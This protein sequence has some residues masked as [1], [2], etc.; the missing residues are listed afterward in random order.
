V[1]Q[2]STN[3][4]LAAYSGTTAFPEQ[5]KY[6]STPDQ[7]TFFALYID[8]NYFA[9]RT[10][11]ANI[12]AFTAAFSSPHQVA[13]SGTGYQ[14]ACFSAD[15]TGL[16]LLDLGGTLYFYD[17]PSFSLTILA[18]TSYGNIT[19]CYLDYPI[20]SIVFV[21]SDSWLIIYYV[22]DLVT[23]TETNSSSIFGNGRFVLDSTFKYYTV[24][25]NDIALFQISSGLVCLRGTF[26][27]VLNQVCNSCLVNCTACVSLAL[28]TS[29][30]ANY[31]LDVNH[32]CVPST[33]AVTQ[34]DED[35]QVFREA[36][37]LLLENYGIRSVNKIPGSRR[38]SPFLSF[39]I[40]I[41]ELWLYQYHERDYGSIM[42]DF[43]SSMQL[44][45]S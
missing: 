28:C 37:A 38:I 3:S 24:F 43:F 21:H 7:T 4:T 17:I 2:P 42:S 34:F 30:V 22:Y 36:I 44:M 8:L 25:N 19:D 26:L 10:L 9:V 15:Y 18:T 1:Y 45:E 6:L 12:S 32:L 5:I 20:N 11:S 41:D 16:F 23:L 40:N 13:L 14:C 39:L 31:S 35:S 29:C 33:N 27:D